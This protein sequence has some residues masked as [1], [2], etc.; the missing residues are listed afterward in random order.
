M[1]SSA[2]FIRDSVPQKI[3]VLAKNVTPEVEYK[4]VS[5]L[6]THD[7]LTNA[8]NR[9]AMPKIE[10]SLR[11]EKYSHSE[12]AVCMIDVDNFKNINDT[13][14]HYE[15]DKWL[16]EIS[17]IIATQC[18]DKDSI[19]RFGGDEFLVYLA[20]IPSEKY[21]V[22][23]ANSVLKEIKSINGNSS[24]EIS[25]SIGI[26]FSSPPHDRF[27]E[28]YRNADKA[29]YKVKKRRRKGSAYIYKEK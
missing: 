20:D 9:S 29:L 5:E 10:N 24:G 25:V 1:E 23:W 3:I 6:A 11:A 19:V 16:K 12:H 22:D 8:M 2:I 15:G 7:Y 21:A 18:S 17:R 13:H 27:D 26:A 28:A 4:K 14:G